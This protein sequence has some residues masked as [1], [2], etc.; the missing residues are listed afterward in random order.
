MERPSH[1]RSGIPRRM[2]TGDENS[3][4]RSSPCRLAI[5]VGDKDRL[6]PPQSVLRLAKAVNGHQPERV[7][8]QVSPSGGRETDCADTGK[9][10]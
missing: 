9:E 7:G 6:A 5:T 8:N 1:A 4:R 10:H 3:G 2:E